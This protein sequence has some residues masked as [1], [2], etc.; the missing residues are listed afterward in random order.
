MHQDRENTHAH[1]HI[2][3][4]DT[5]DR[6]LRFTREKWQNL[7]REWALVY[8]REFGRG[9]AEEHEL[10]KQETREYKRECALARAEG[11][12]PRLE[13]PDRADRGESPAQLR[14]RELRRYG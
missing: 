10:K 9:L 6:K 12:A 11:R 4:R 13:K 8:E 1:F 3:T 2:Q 14:E 5:G 7:D